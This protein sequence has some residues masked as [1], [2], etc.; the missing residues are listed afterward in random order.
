L[1]PD[2]KKMS[3]SKGNV[4]NPDEII[5]KFGADT[6]R[7]YEMFM[8]PIES[9]KPWD[10]SAVAGMYR[11]LQRMHAAILSQV[12]EQATNAHPEQQVVRRKLHQTI[13]KVTADIPA[14]KFNTALAALMECLNQFERSSRSSSVVLPKEEVVAWVQ[15]LAPFA[16]FLAEELYQKIQN[17]PS[18]FISLHQSDWPQADPKLAA[19]EQFEIPIQVDGKVRAR[20]Q[21]AADKLLD[22]AF[23]IERAQADPV[24]QRWILGSKPT[25]RYIS[26][27]ILSFS[28]Q[29]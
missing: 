1:G 15:L 10:V 17:S 28:T 23:V 9:D 7:I 25:A 29:V 20:V 26:G 18:Q 19:E 4:I 24:V 3:K 8:G 6:L 2:G 14:L 27:K 11:F 21:I 13:T 22:E 12:G 16:P 5:E